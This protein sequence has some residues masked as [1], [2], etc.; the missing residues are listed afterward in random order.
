MKKHIHLI[1]T[2]V[3]I[4][5]SIGE[6]EEGVDVLGALAKLYRSTA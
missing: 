3:Y 6:S 5:N 1:L 2:T 4:I